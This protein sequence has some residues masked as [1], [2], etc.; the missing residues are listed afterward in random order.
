LRVS[1]VFSLL[2]R[3]ALIGACGYATWR[4]VAI[5]RA[6]WAASEGT[7]QGFERALQFD[8]SDPDL[9]AR[10]AIFRNESDDP[11]PSV[12]A[13]LR[14]AARLNPLNSAVL[15]TLGL[16]EELGG[17]KAK[18]EADLVRAAEVDHQ[19]KPAWTLA[20]YYFRTGQP[21]KSWATLQRILRLDPLG[22]DPSPVFD[23]CWQEAGQTGETSAKSAA[24]IAGLVPAGK[25]AIQYLD[26]LMR[27]R[28]TE[29]ALAAWPRALAAA[30][31]AGT[32]APDGIRGFADYLANSGRITEAV[33]VWNE[34]VEHGFIQSGH[35]NPAQGLSIGDPDFRFGIQPVP[36]IFGWHV[37][38]VAGVFATG[39]PGSLNFEISGDE[40]PTFQVLSTHAALR[41]ATKYRL[42]WKVDGSAL[43]SPRDPGFTF[44]IVEQP[45]NTATA[46]PPL[47]SAASAACEFTTGA[48]AGLAMIQLTYARAQGTVRVSGTLHLLSVR[49]EIAH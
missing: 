5:A 43:N 38:D 8:P 1:D 33:N 15:M 28:R 6:D 16:R 34:L 32:P 46:C 2:G 25:L 7:I 30:D 42:V 49:M 40:A 45:G 10:A 3:L 23:L 47:L 35:L 29:A 9:V 11:A 18:G 22:Y 17:D 31:A 24:R 26:Y 19:F 39:A 21:E 13:E 12:D 44:Q 4:A 14:R 37:A 48:D 20:N 27:T 41:R 36:Q